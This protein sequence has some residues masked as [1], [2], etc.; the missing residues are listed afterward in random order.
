MLILDELHEIRAEVRHVRVALLRRLR[1][2]LQ[3]HELE[4]RRCDRH[5][6][7]LVDRNLHAHLGEAVRLERAVAFDQFVEHAA[8]RPDIAA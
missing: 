5:R 4:R 1:E 2:T 3:D 8:E 7:G 6:R